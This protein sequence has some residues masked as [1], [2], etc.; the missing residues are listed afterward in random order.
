MTAVTRMPDVDH[1]L[2]PGRATEPPDHAGRGGR[3]QAGVAQRRVADEVAA[4]RVGEPDRQHQ[5]Q[6]DGSP[7]AQL[8]PSTTS[9]ASADQQHERRELVAGDHRHA[10]QHDSSSTPTRSRRSGSSG[11]LARHQTRSS[12]GRQDVGAPG[13]G[14]QHRE[15]Q[16]DHARGRGRSR[17]PAGTGSP[18]R[19]SCPGRRPT[20][21]ATAGACPTC[22][23]RTTSASAASHSSPLTTGAQGV[24]SSAW[25]PLARENVPMRAK[26]PG[27]LK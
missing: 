10:Q 18:G 14:A 19:S 23:A 5:A 12:A 21:S 15:Q 22:S 17:R 2:V 1:L 16:G 20:G 3:P 4:G 27:Q 6:Q 24:R 7:G 25:M 13:P 26:N 9:A 11:V 8:R